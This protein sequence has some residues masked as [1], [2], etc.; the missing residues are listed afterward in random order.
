MAHHDA[1]CPPARAITGGYAHPPPPKIHAG[2][3]HLYTYYS[4]PSISIS[5]P[6]Y[7]SFL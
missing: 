7:I 1:S 5:A 4:V 6:L 3:I 2:P